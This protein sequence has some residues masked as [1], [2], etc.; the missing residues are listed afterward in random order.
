M[1]PPSPSAVDT[2]EK[3][4]RKEARRMRGKFHRGIRDCM[5]DNHKKAQA[6]YQQRNLLSVCG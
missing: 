2:T 3:G 6:Y 4:L 1:N 5:V